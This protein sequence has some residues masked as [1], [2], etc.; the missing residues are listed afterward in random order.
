MKRPSE[1]KMIKMQILDIYIEYYILTY[2]QKSLLTFYFLLIVRSTLIYVWDLH[3]LYGPFF[4][5]F[6]ISISFH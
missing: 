3:L 5:H 4:S 1:D 2:S 6:F